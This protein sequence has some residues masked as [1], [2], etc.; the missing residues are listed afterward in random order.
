MNIVRLCTGLIVAIWQV[1]AIGQIPPGPLPPPKS[2]Q[3]MKATPKP[4][5]ADTK[6]GQN[7]S[8][9]TDKKD[10]QGNDEKA[11]KNLMPGSLA[12]CLNCATIISIHEASRRPK[13]LWMTGTTID[14][15]G[16]SNSP[17]N[18]SMSKPVVIPNLSSGAIINR[19]QEVGLHR[20]LG[21]E[22]TLQM[23]DGS[24]K[25]LT[26]AARPA[27]NIGSKVKIIGKTLIPD[28]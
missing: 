20:T 22:V 17:G 24:T 21:F 10:E 19:D 6:P 11:S 9:S 14:R 5:T 16:N 1:L 3:P 2:N 4:S 7:S 27:Y 28:Y 25:V 23:T 18:T 12:E 26:L 13:P 15:S 8:Q